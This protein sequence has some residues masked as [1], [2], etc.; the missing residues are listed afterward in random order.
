MA[1]PRHSDVSRRRTAHHPL[2]TLHGPELP[3]RVEQLSFGKTP[4]TDED[5]L[6]TQESL[7]KPPRGR[8]LETAS[9]EWLATYLEQL[10]TRR[11]VG[12]AALLGTLTAAAIVIAWIE[13]IHWVCLY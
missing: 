9:I 8:V 6:S 2:R 4:R 12:R 13:M 11:D 3:L 7:Y 1:Q 5:Q 10:P